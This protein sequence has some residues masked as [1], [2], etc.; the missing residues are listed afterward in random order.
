MYMKEI[1]RKGVCLMNF[2]K[3]FLKGMV[4]GA[5]AIAPGVSG[6]ALATIF[7]LYDKIINFIAN[8]IKDFKKN[9]LF[10]FPIGLGGLVG[11]LAFSRIIEYL[12]KY[13]EVDVRY[14]FTGLMLGTIPAV[15]HQANRNGYR[16]KYLLPFF[17]TFFLTLAI[18]LLE[19]KQ[20]VTG[21]TISTSPMSII[22]YGIVIGFGSIIPGIS[23]SLILMYIGSY[24][25]VISAISNLQIYT[26]FYLAIGFVVSVLLFAKIISI[27]F[28][29][30]YGATY[31]AIVGLVIGSIISIFPGFELTYNYVLKLVLMIACFILS[32]SLSK[33]SIK[34]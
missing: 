7:G 12:F 28:D 11:V 16:K 31:Y 26:L 6:G 25:M 22:I 18:T 20:G 9:V 32:Y 29:R 23:S 21:N 14:A 3:G 4:I 1:A 27:L 10:F 8:F 24:E 30:A 15:I 19:N 5:A 17:L 2:M 13:Y 34:G 33:L